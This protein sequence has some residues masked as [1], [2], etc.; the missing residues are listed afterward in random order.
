MSEQARA[1]TNILVS[2]DHDG[3]PTIPPKG[4]Q[5]LHRSRARLISLLCATAAAVMVAIPFAGAATAAP[6]P[7]A[8]HGTA[9]QATT[10]HNTLWATQLFFDNHGVPW[11]EASL[12]PLQ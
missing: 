8:R 10:A 3:W 9:S 7:A 2:H 11:S 4:R 12:A 1:Q 6:A 5:M